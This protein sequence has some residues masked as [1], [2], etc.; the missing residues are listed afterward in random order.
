MSEESCRKNKAIVTG[1][2]Q[3]SS[4]MTVAQV[5]EQIIQELKDW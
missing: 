5:V 1:K 3:I 4:R 2:V